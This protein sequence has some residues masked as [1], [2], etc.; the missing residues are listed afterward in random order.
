[1]PPEFKV[2]NE[3]APCLHNE[4]FVQWDDYLVSNDAEILG[5]DCVY[6]CVALTLYDIVGQRGGMA[7]IINE[8]EISD[9]DEKTIVTDML[10]DME[11]VEPDMPLI[12]YATITGDA[13]DEGLADIVKEQ[14][15][16]L[17]IPIIGEHTKQNDISA[18]YLELSTG[19]ITVYANLAKYV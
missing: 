2:I 3:V 6:S 18:V 17:R 16:K 4:T 8:R 5:T 7:H 19:K 13:N 14:L 11:G 10:L 1:M 15:T 9:I 12:C